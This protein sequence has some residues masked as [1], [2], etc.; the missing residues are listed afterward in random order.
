METYY[1]RFRADG[2]GPLVSTFNERLRQRGRT[3][4]V[5]G[6]GPPARGVVRGV[7]A[8]GGLELDTDDGVRVLHG[9]SV[10]ETT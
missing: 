2:F 9:E 5:T 3:V 6:G 4:R 10:K 8:H 7:D 1:D